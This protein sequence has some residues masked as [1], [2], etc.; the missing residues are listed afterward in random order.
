MTTT[1][2]TYV[3]TTDAA[4]I[5]GYKVN[6][7]SAQDVDCHGVKAVALAAEG[8]PKLRIVARSVAQGMIAYRVAARAAGVQVD[9]YEIRLRKV[10]AANERH[11]PRGHEGYFLDNGK[12]VAIIRN[13][14]Q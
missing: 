14:C 13:E 4:Q 2:E 3:M 9:S 8:A 11:I 5:I 12:Y 7:I 10:Y 1:S 6:T